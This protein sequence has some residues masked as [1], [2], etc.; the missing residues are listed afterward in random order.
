LSKAS[1]F[2]GVVLSPALDRLLRYPV[3]SSHGLDT[4]TRRDLS[5]NLGDLFVCGAFSFAQVC[6]LGRE[7]KTNTPRWSFCW[8]PAKMILY[9]MQTELGPLSPDGASMAILNIPSAKLITSP[10]PTTGLR[11]LLR[12]EA[13]AF[14]ELWQGLE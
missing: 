12:A 11:P 10:I 6:L 7:G 8:E 1:R 4:R 14:I 9:L 3:R 5:Q 2:A 13:R